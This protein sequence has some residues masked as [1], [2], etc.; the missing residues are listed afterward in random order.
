MIAI[1]SVAPSMASNMTNQSQALKASSLS[2]VGNLASSGDGNDA[3]QKGG[4]VVIPTLRFTTSDS[5]MLE[6]ENQKKKKVKSSSSSIASETMTNL[7][8]HLQMVSLL[9]KVSNWSWDLFELTR[10]SRKRPLFT[11]SHYLFLSADLYKTFEINVECFL[12]FVTRIESGYREDVPYH[13]S[14]HASDVLHGVSYLKMSCEHIVQPT[15][16]ETLCLY[17]AAIIHDY[18]CVFFFYIYIIHI[19]K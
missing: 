5:E 16:F 10:V 9:E 8:T 6:D 15:P 17:V 11:L 3:N 7:N 14:I 2:S 18:E 19:L 12:N 4:G 1:E 13:N